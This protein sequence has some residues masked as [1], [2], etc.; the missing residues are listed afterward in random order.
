VVAARE[1]MIDRLMS[2]IRKAGLKPDGIDLNAFALVRM[3]GEDGTATLDP[4]AQPARVICHLGGVT[5]MAIAAGP[6]CLFTRPLQ[7]VWTDDDD[8]FANSLAEEIRLSLDFHMAQPNARA[9]DSIV[10]TGPGATHEAVAAELENRTAL[11]VSVAAPL[12]AFGDNG[13]PTGED[14]ARYTVA[15]GLALGGQA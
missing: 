14:P 12:G 5:N 11:P 1:S 9:V 4:A 10:L 6:I 8:G 15:A 7:T 13:V 2:A 3:V